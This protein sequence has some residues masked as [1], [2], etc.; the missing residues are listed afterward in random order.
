VSP[1]AIARG[2][3]QFDYE[4]LDRAIA[5]GEA[6]GFA[7]LVGDPRGRLVGA[8]IAAPG[9]GEAIAE[10][11][12]WVSQGAKIDVV[13]RTVHHYPTLA[14]GAA[15]VA[16]EHVAARY[17]SPWMRAVARPVLAT[18]RALERPR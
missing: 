7:K 6:Y 2:V 18:L 1:A 4:R 11:A 12:A 16:D 15:R 10:L 5:A 3:A 9:G 14:E 13:S 17:A 8:M